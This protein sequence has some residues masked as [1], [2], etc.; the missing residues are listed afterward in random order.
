MLS[1]LSVLITSEYKME[2]CNAAIYHSTELFPTEVI[3]RAAE[4]S[5]WVLRHET[6]RKAVSF[7]RRLAH[8]ARPHE[9]FL[10]ESSKTVLPP[11]GAWSHHF[12]QGLWLGRKL[13][14]DLSFCAPNKRGKGKRC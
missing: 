5:S 11:V 6:M 3:M 14:P 10:Q 9:K 7:E 2:M 4:R 1:K 12:L 13:Q 8:P